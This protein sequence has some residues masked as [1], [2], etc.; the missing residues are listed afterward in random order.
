MVGI[1][2][3]YNPEL[4][5]WP[6]LLLHRFKRTGKRDDIY[7][8]TKCGIFHAPDGISVNG[9]PE[10]I[11]KACEKSLARLGVDSFDLYY[12]HRCGTFTQVI[13]GCSSALVVLTKTFLSKCVR[14]TDDI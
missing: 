10:Y 2:V 9:S 7:L 8:A 11:K 13:C 12:L 4:P 6:S 1:G 3:E 14:Q 5:A